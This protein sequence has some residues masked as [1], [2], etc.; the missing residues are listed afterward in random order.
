VI[1]PQPTPVQR[2]TRRREGSGDWRD[3][4]ASTGRRTWTNWSGGVT[5]HPTASFAPRTEEELRAVV[6]RCADTDRTI[7]VVGAGHSF[8]PVAAT[9]DVLVSLERYSG[10]TDVDVG[11]RPATVRAGTRLRDLNRA[12]A[13][14]GLAM[15]NLGD[16]DAQS[17]A[18]ALATGTHGTGVDFGVLSTQ[19]A[20]LRLLTATGE[21]VEC[22]P[23]HRPE[24]FRAAQ[25]S[26]GALGIVTRVTLD[27]EPAYRLRE[28]KRPM[29]IDRVLDDLDRLRER[30]RHAEFWWFPHTE[31]ALVK[32]LDRI[33]ESVGDSPTDDATAGD[34]ATVG[35]APGGPAADGGAGRRKEFLDAA[36]ETAENLAWGGLCRV[37]ARWPAL[38]PAANRLTAA[39]LGGGTRVGP[40]HE[41]FPTRRNVRFEETEYGVPI[42]DWEGAFRAVREAANEEPGVQFPVEVRF[43]AG[44]DVPLS[45]SHGRDSAFIA[46]H[47]YHRKDLESYFDACEAALLERAGRP[48]WGKRHS[49]SA[50]A[51]R[52]RYPEWDAFHDVRRRFDPDGRFHNDHLRELF[53]E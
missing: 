27:L 43:V 7:R 37:G 48:H 20:G 16:V 1:D 3:L 21:I 40:S 11:E 32:T 45:P 23:S 12:L 4:P 25:V 9:D 39:T 34:A 28:V 41:I 47:G 19:V 53:G 35:S 6:E 15:E 44:D 49:L 42:E 24:L 18:G 33:D 38:T 29:A 10:V 26:L 46:V 2:R 14:R 30:H 36:D 17:I 50:S 13:G 5:S 8:S 52:A 51:L 31:T 22:S